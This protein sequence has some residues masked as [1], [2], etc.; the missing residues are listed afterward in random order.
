MLKVIGIHPSIIEI[1]RQ[2]YNA[3]KATVKMSDGSMSDYFDVA[4]G[5]R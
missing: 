2:L 4:V 1:L 3:T 5:V